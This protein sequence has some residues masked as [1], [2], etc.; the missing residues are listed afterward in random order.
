MIHRQK[1]ML[2]IALG[3]LVVLIVILLAV[4]SCGADDA[5]D[6]PDD[7]DAG[8]VL[9][10]AEDVV[11]LDWENED[12]TISLAQNDDGSWYWTGNPDFPLDAAYPEQLVQ[13]L[14]ALTPQQTIT[15]GDTLESYGLD[16]PSRT[17]TATH[18]DGT[19]TLYQLGRDTTDGESCYLLLDG[20]ESTVYIIDGS[21]RDQLDV[22]IYDMMDLPELPDLTEENLVSIQLSGAAETT[23][24]AADEPGSDDETV[25]EVHWYSGDTDVTDAAG[26]LVTALASLSLDSCADFD[27]TD[28]AV[29]LCGLDAPTAKLQVVYLDEDGAEQTLTLFVG[30]SSA[31]A[32]GYYVRMN[33]DTTVY[34]MTSATLETVLSVAQD[35]LTS[36]SADS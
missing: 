18:A 14:S 9:A 26:D 25:T 15:D 22:G 10:A 17:L 8:E 2:L 21:L 35:G 30:S 20:D 4:K 31:D 6:S 23:L 28:E 5:A 29:T 27:P 32:S 3:I 33:D 1:R 7:A 24:T 36:T 19:T 11:A 12:T 34:I 16:E 13:T